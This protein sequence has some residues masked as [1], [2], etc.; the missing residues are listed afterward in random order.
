MLKRFIVVFF[1]L[2]AGFIQAQEGTTSPYSFYGIG[3]LKFK[4][5]IENRAMGG[6]SMY[7]DSIHL[8]IMNPA[9]IADLKLVNFTVGASHRYLTMRTDDEKQKASTTSLDYLALGIPMGKVG[10][11]F[12]L[13]PYSSVGYKLLSES[14]D[15]STQYTGTGGVNKAFLGLAYK[16]TPKFNLGV[17]VN[18]NFGKIE[19]ESFHKEDDIQLEKFSFLKSVIFY[20]DVYL[21]FDLLNHIFF[22]EFQAQEHLA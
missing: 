7:S 14:E 8:S 16:V 6:I 13:I 9:G 11:S 4:G 20:L 22:Y 10:A 1:I 5:T 2:V 18:Y 3:Q 12:G 21:D 19:N 17:D 15:A